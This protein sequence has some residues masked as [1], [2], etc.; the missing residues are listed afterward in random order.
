MQYLIAMNVEFDCN[1]FKVTTLTKEYTYSSYTHS[2]PYTILYSI[3]E[4]Y[5]LFMPN[6]N[7]L[8]KKVA[9]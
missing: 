9:I 3:V 5:F 1:T 6:N 4:I 7:V 8:L 2:L